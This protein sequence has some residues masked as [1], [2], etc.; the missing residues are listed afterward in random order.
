VTVF[1]IRLKKTEFNRQCKGQTYKTAEIILQCHKV[2][3]LFCTEPY[4]KDIVW[5]VITS[6]LLQTL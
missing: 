2:M 5:A 3:D 4:R 6:G 1:I